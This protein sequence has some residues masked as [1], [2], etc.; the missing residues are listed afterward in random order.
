MSRWRSWALLGVLGAA[1][2]GAC[3]TDHD[4]LKHKP[5]AS[6]G[7]AGEAG[8]DADADL[9]VAVDVVVD[10]FVEPPGSNVLTLLHGVVDAPRI[11]FCFAK[12][13]GGVAAPPL[14]APS[15]A[16]GLGWG[17][18]LALSAIAGLDWTTD[19]IQPIVIAATD[20]ATLSGK[21]CAD[22]MALAESYADAGGADASED[23]GA[24]DASV[25]AD[26]SAGPADADAGA[27]DA[28][29][30]LP[31]PPPVR[32]LELPVL[33]AGTLSGGYS[34]LL[35]ATGCIGGP[36]FT[37]SLETYVCGQS[38]SPSSPTL[39]ESLVQLS[40]VGV[41]TALGL[42]VMNAAL[43][44]DPIDLSS[45]PPE[46]SPLPT[47]GIASGVV[48]GA[49]SPK[50]PMLTF[51]KVSFGNPI[52]ASALEVTSQGSS[53]AVFASPWSAA[54]A[55]GGIPDVSDGSTYA[56]VLVGPRPNITGT[57]WWNG[58]RLSV[59]PTAPKP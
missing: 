13:D 52:S 29:A 23:G 43:A 50:P 11:A 21:T 10:Q 32:S 17:N 30:E 28:E 56:I 57:K 5:S 14:G 22:A 59:I 38:Y 51:S 6:G 41:S 3:S 20:F 46:G 15:P 49:L 55:S 4:A 48:Y 45:V 35:V 31:P 40:R 9:D 36:G 2:A 53:S 7:A 54:F 47:L 19:D 34:N 1:V 16:A 42:Q 37:D 12:V 44:S 8:A 33:P 18:G 58:P 39:S 26:A 24:A 25:D 27:G